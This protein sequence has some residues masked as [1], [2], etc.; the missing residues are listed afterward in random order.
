MGTIDQMKKTLVIVIVIVI[1]MQVGTS[2]TEHHEE[3]MKDEINFF[4]VGNAERSLEI[5]FPGSCW[6]LS[7]STI[8][9]TKLRV[10]VKLQFERN[11]S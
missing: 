1:V 8:L 7:N 10:S 11:C 5:L 4:P 2:S 3:M 9:C 6:H